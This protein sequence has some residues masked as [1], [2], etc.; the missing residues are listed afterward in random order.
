MMYRPR[1]LVEKSA[2]PA[3]DSRSGAPRTQLGPSS[4]VEAHLAAARELRAI[5]MRAWFRTAIKFTLNLGRRVQPKPASAFT[6][7]ISE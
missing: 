3:L 6:A 2:V 1:C 5:H 4:V 7:H